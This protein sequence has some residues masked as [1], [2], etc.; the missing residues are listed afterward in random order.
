MNIKG[1]DHSLVQG[2]S[3]STFLNFSSLETAKPIEAKFHVEPP[4]D[5]GTKVC[6]NDSGHMTNMA[7]MPIY[8]KNRKKIFFSGNKGP[9]TLKPG[10]LHWVLEYYQVF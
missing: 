9:M 7:V 6:S 10:M 3:H 8:G 1:Q 5:R 2:H 4:W